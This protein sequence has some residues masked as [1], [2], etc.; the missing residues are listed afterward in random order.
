[1]S[2]IMIPKE[3]YKER[4]LKAG[5]LIKEKGLDVL[6]VNGT[7]SD[8]ANPRYFSAFWPVF[9]RSGVAIN[10]DGNTALLVG[11]ESP[12]FAADKAVIKDIFMMREYIES[13]NP[14]Y[15]HLQDQMQTYN[16][17]FKFLGVNG[18]KLKIGIASLIDTTMVMYEGLKNAYPEAEIIDASDLMVE[19]RSIKSENEI[20]CLREGARIS[21]IAVQE[22]LKVIQ[23]GMTEL[24]LVGVAH[25]VFYREGAEAEGLPIYCFSQKSTQHAISRSG[26]DIIQK[27]DIVQLNFSAKVDGYSSAIGMPISMGPMTGEKREIVEFLWEA[28]KWTENKLSQGAGL[29]A[30]ELAIGYEEFFKENG[31]EEVYVYGPCHST[32]MIEVEAP[33]I[34]TSSTF[35]LKSNMTFQIDTFGIGSNFGCRWEKPIVVREGG[36]EILSPEIG[37]I[38]EIDC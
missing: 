32:G 9:E 21:D 28:H 33:W 31:R 29:P 16:D 17:V 10:G 1:M 18:K 5:K 26:H 38:H 6:V 4:A 27:G 3:E 8:Y 15:P 13:A 2:R 19:L 20:A 7:E 34:E 14:E 22:V 24:Q 35:G 30:S 11:P 23:P 25:E 37:K 12:I 36:I